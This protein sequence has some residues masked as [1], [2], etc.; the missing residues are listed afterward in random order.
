MRFPILILLALCTTFAFAQEASAPLNKVASARRTATPPK[1]DGLLLESI[2]NTPPTF[3][4]LTEYLP[5]FGV[6]EGEDILTKVWIFYDNTGLYIGAEMMD[7]SQRIKREFTKRDDTG[8]ADWFSVLIDTYRDGLNGYEFGVTTAGVQ[9]DKRYSPT[10]SRGGGGG[11]SGIGGSSSGSWGGGDQTWDAVWHSAVHVEENRWTAEIKIPYSAIRFSD[12]PEQRFGFNVQRYR[13]D[14]RQELFWS[15][16]RPEIDNFISQW[17]ILENI[18]DVKA[19]LILSLSPYVAVAADHYTQT[20]W[21]N[22][23]TAGADL[24]WGINQ[25]FTLDAALIPDFGQVQS[26][27]LVHN[28]TPFEVQYNEK[29]PFFMEGTELFNKGGY[30]YSRRIGG[31]P[32]YYYSIPLEENEVVT[33]NPSETKLINTLKFSGRTAKGLGIGVLNA[34]TSNMYATIRDTLTGETRRA[35]TT[36]LINATVLVL[37]QTLRNNSYLSVVNTSVIRMSKEAYNSNVTGLLF[38]F[39]DKNRRYYLQGQGT[40]STFSNKNAGFSYT[41]RGGK[42][43]GLWQY[44]VENAFLDNNIDINDLGLQ[45]ERNRMNISGYLSYNNYTP[46]SWYARYN[47]SVTPTY[48]QRFI[49]WSYEQAGIETAGMLLLKDYT[50]FRITGT[51]ALSSKDFYEPQKEGRYYNKPDGMGASFYVSTNYN[52]PV[53]LDMTLSWEKYFQKGYQ[54]YSVQLKPGLRISQ[55]VTLFLTTGI[56]NLFNDYGFH[57]RNPEPAGSATDSIVF[58]SRNRSVIENVVD[59]RFSFNDKMNITLAARH[60]VSKV[61]NKEFFFLNPNGDL[62]PTRFKGTDGEV[63]NLFYIDFLYTWRF[64]PGSEIN[65][66]W[67][68][69]IN[70]QGIETLRD[71]YFKEIGSLSN[72]PQRNILS[73]KL[74]YYLDWMTIMGKGRKNL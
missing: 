37:D 40:A 15:P 53:F 38:R 50:M 70:P 12:K 45:R 73:L 69:E 2:W 6:T 42:A 39:N 18:T 57:W 64:A 71:S 29:R 14:T 21:Q 27:P 48:I 19:P 30:F 24:K 16:R 8:N 22:S 3:E 28:L 36:P 65:L 51:Y 67:K 20:G 72:A 34:I 5:T 61:Q 7:N 44:Y 9:F 66:I 32:M 62:D 25:A 26:D 47:V 74:I 68:N 59:G 60:Y 11:N 1:I 17:G 56:N 31:Q 43:R 46:S 13:R 54:G 58:A 23:F 10:T 33:D 52:K 49:P 63:Y 35:Q 41:L 4:G 55:K